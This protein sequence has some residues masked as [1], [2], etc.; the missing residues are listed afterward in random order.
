MLLRTDLHALSCGGVRLSTRAVMEGH[1]AK[2][3]STL[4][5]MFPYT[6]KDIEEQDREALVRR[7]LL[8][9]DQLSRFSDKK[10]TAALTD[11][12]IVTRYMLRAGE[13]SRWQGSY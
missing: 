10:E 8:T 5:R 4:L 13:S 3:D 1:R 11:I 9:R 7:G 2:L 6:H 12:S